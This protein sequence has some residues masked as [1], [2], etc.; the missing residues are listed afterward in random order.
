VFQN[1]QFNRYLS[2]WQ[3]LVLHARMHGLSA[4]E[5]EP[6]ITELLKQQG[7]YERR[8]QPTEPLSGGMKRR[9]ALLRALIQQPAVLFL[10]EPTTGL[11][12][13]ARRELWATLAEMKLQEKQREVLKADAVAQAATSVFGRAMAK[14]S[15]AWVELAVV[16]APM[17]DPAAIA[18]RLADEQRRVMA[19]LHKEFME[20]AAN[21]SAA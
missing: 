21:R 16:L 13:H 17:T 9:V 19:G 10:D 18:D 8:N 3:N 5:Y 4:H 1:N 12:P 2:L 14:F 7:L 6:K 20:D 11:D 15:E